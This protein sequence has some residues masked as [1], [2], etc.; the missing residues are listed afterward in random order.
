MRNSK[1]N[2]KRRNTRNNTNA[3]AATHQNTSPRWQSGTYTNSVIGPSSGKSVGFKT[4]ID[5]DKRPN[6]THVKP[7]KIPEP[8]N[9]QITNDKKVHIKGKFLIK[10]YLF[11]LLF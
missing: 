8:K 7:P 4:N 9:E 10:N 2:R 6:G 11:I 1:R 5:D 3:N